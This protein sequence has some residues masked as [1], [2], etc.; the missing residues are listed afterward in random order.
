MMTNIG[1]TKA[2]I[3]LDLVLSLNRG[4]CDLPYDRVHIAHKQYEQLVSYGIL[5]EETVDA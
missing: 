3:I 4:D 5:K 2:D 1:K